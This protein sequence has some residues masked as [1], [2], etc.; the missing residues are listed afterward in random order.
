MFDQLQEVVNGDPPILTQTPDNRFSNDLM[1]FVN[2]WYVSM[3]LIS[4]VLPPPNWGADGEWGPPSQTGGGWRVGNSAFQTWPKFH[5]ARRFLA[6]GI[7][8]VPSYVLAMFG[9][10]TLL[11]TIRSLTLTKM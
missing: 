2:S 10:Y 11:A 8:R 7:I 1:V 6:R 4:G 5:G 3:D 9:Y